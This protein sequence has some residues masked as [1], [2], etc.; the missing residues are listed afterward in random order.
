MRSAN[1]ICRD[2]PNFRR[3]EPKVRYTQA[4][5][6]FSIMAKTVRITQVGSN[7]AEAQKLALLQ[8]LADYSLS[9]SPCNGSICCE[10]MKKLEGLC[11]ANLI[12]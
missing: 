8:Q 9:L 5:W 11:A 4:W 7:L 6:S 1:F 12:R 2:E 10:K 3:E